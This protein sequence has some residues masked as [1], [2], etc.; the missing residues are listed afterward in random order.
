MLTE[1][2]RAI[3]TTNL[4]VRAGE[5]V[6]VFT[7]RIPEGEALDGREQSRREMLGDIAILTSEMGK[8][9]S[10][11]ITYHEFPSTGSHGAE[12]PE[13]L[14]HLAFSE[15]PVEELKRNGLFE[16]LL[17]KE[18]SDGELKRVAGIIRKYKGSAVH[19]VI[20]LS[21][22]STSHTR[23][24]H[25][26]TGVCRCRYVSMPL[27]DASMLEGA[28]CIDWLLLERRTK[29]IARA[30]NRAA[31]IW[32]QT[33]NGTS[34]SFSKTGR[35][36]LTDTGILTRPGAFG[37]LPA[38]EGCLAP[39]EGTSHGRLVL[40]WAPTRELVSPVT[41][42][43]EKGAV[44]KIEGEEPY[45]ELLQRKCGERPENGNIAEFGIGTNERAQR[46]DNILE[47]EKILGTIH[48]ALGD[49]SSFGGRVMTPF[50]QDFVFFKPTITLTYKD[51][52]Q[53]LL[54]K[55]GHF[56]EGMV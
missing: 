7:D 50:H 46:P 30:V 55:D 1:P 26:L 12:P 17:S 4:G 41:L 45:T 3:F 28:M 48:I 27:F 24:R 36:A 37:N 31:S 56:A 11:E 52:T 32:V 5:R 9:F 38:G 8:A 51:G 10:K 21:N 49:N 43:V 39:L 34:L 40:E 22:Y 6:L 42:T 18:I 53:R 20:A 47:S 44:V 19:V 13:E 29:R 54:M 16:K 15:R 2:L 14:W 35:K 25:L 23:F 33:L